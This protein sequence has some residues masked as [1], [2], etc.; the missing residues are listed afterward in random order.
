MEA[1]QFHVQV[2][3]GPAILYCITLWLAIFLPGLRAKSWLVAF[4]LMRFVVTAYSY[5]PHLLLR[6]GI[7]MPDTYRAVLVSG[8]QS[9]VS[10]VSYAVLVGLVLAITPKVTGS[11]SISNV[12]FLFRGRLTRHI[13]WIVTITL[14]TV[15]VSI[16]V[17]LSGSSSSDKPVGAW[18][19][20]PWLTYL[21]WL[22]VSAWIALATQV[23]RWHDRDKSGWW[24]LIGI[25][26]IIGDIWAIV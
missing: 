26:P 23:K 19:L 4:L 25:V 8:V 20:V 7:L 24:V 14:L 15:N 11:T 10:I 18:A 16:A 13:F 2:F 17:T 9:V 22:P 3:W 6:K 5:V 12:L 1:I 21:L